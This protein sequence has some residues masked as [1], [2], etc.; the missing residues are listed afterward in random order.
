MR[1]LCTIFLCIFSILILGQNWNLETNPFNNPYRN[2]YENSS[3]K[4]EQEIKRDIDNVKKIIRNSTVIYEHFKDERVKS[5]EETQNNANASFPGAPGEPV[6]ID[7]YLILLMIAGFALVI[8]Y[9]KNR[10]TA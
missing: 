6:P 1:K 2:P 4:K 8:I 5:P 7:D 10:E 9:T 3:A